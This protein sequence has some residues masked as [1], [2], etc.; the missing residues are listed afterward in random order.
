M[1]ATGELSPKFHDG[2]AKKVKSSSVTTTGELSPKFHDGAAVDSESQK[3]T[4][5]GNID[6]NVPPYPGEIAPS[7]G[8]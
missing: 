1:T 5:S 7:S 8:Q 6:I 3:K 4:T 2:A